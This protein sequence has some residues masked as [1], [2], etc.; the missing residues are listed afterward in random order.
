MRAGQWDRKAFGGT[1]LRGKVLG[2]I[3]LGRIGAHVTHIARAFGMKV[4]A[5]DPYLTES[6]AQALSVELVTLEDLLGRADVV[7]LHL[8]LSDATRHLLNPDRLALMKPTAVLVNTARGELVDEEALLR[9]VEQK[10]IAGAALDVFSEEPLPGDS[11]LRKTDRI[12]L[13]PHLAASTAEAQERVALEICTAV[14]DALLGGDVAGAVNVPGVSA[15]AMRRVRPLIDLARRLGRLGATLA[16]GRVHAIDVGYGGTDQ[17]APR[18]TELAAAEGALA[19]MGVG[20]VSLVNAQPLAQERGIVLSRR[21]GPPLQGFETT[22]AVAV[23]AANRTVLVVGALVADRGR[24]VRIDGFTVDVP[25]EGYLI[26]LRNR[27]VPGVIGRVGTVLGEA[28][29]N[30]AFYHQSRRPEPDGSVALAAISVDHPPGRDVLDRLSK[31][32]D[33]TEVSFADLNG[34]R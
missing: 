15:E 1:E 26:V 3:G 22:I 16:G 23:R 29:T 20:P 31:L 32:P 13:T 21:V 34:G 8:P 12:I 24:I 6:R 5:H 27:D 28:S 17:E 18:P 25:A 33:V 2:V 4:L 9:A 10:R 30:I 7:T 19:A 14:R 11:P